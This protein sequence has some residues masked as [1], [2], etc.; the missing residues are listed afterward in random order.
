MATYG[1]YETVGRLYSIGARSVYS[2]REVEGSKETFVVKILSPDDVFGEDPQDAV[3]AFT[4]RAQIQQSL[5]QARA[6]AWAEVFEV[7]TRDGEVYY[8]SA[9]AASSAQ[10]LVAGKVRTEADDLYRVV[11]R[12]IQGLR[13]LRSTSQRAHGNLKPSN[14]LIDRT[15]DVASASVLLTDP[16][17]A[18][19]KNAA[20]AEHADVRDLGEIIHQLV[21]HIPFRAMGGYPIEDSP[22][23]AR[24]GRFAEQWRA[25]CNRML[26]P[27]AQPG[28][29]SVEAIAQEI[30]GLRP[31]GGKGGRTPLI[32]AGAA[33][34]L[35]LVAGAAYVALRPAPTPTGPAPVQFEPAEWARLCDA[36]LWAMALRDALRDDGI[37][38]RLRE[39]PHLA[40][41]L[42]PLAESEV[43]LDVRRI[44]G[45]RLAPASIRDDPP[46]SVRNPSSAVVIRDALDWVERAEAAVSPSQWPAART[47]A[48]AESRLRA[49]GWDRFADYPRALQGRLAQRDDAT[50]RSFMAAIQ[51]AARVAPQLDALLAAID[52]AQPG[53]EDQVPVQSRVVSRILNAENDDSIIEGVRPSHIATLIAYLSDPASNVR[54]T[55]VVAANPGGT[56]FDPSGTTGQATPVDPPPVIPDPPPV[57]DIGPDP[58]TGWD[59]AGTIESVRSRLAERWT[60]DLQGSHVRTAEQARADLDAVARLVAQVS[61][62][63]W[64]EPTRD[65]VRQQMDEA[66]TRADLVSRAVDDLR[67]DHE[68]RLAA[69]AQTAAEAQA[70]LAAYVADFRARTPAG[71]RSPALLE[72]WEQGRSALIAAHT[73]PARLSDLR[74]AAG[75]LERAVGIAESGIPLP[76]PF[77]AGPSGF[78]AAAIAERLAAMREAAI[79]RAWAAGVPDSFGDTFQRAVESERGTLAAEVT[80]IGAV[81]ADL[82][83]AEAG[84]NAV[85]GWNDSL[86]RAEPPR[87]L[88]VIRESWT[89][90]LSQRQW[91]AGVAG[92]VA[93]RLTDLGAAMDSVGAADPAT[94]PPYIRDEGSPFVAA[95][96]AW[97]RTRA[98]PGITLE[99][100]QAM[101]QRLRAGLGSIE[102]EARRTLLRSELEAGALARWTAAIESAATPQEYESRWAARNMVESGVDLTALSQRTQ[103]N[104]A[105]VFG[106]QR[107]LTLGPSD[108]EEEARSRLERII[109]TAEGSPQLWQS[110]PGVSAWIAQIRAE[111]S[112]GSGVDLAALERSGPGASGGWQFRA[113][114]PQAQRIAYSINAG[115]ESITLEFA[116]LDTADGVSQPVYVGT[117][118]VSVRMLG[119]AAN[120][121][122][123]WG[124]IASAWG[125]RLTNPS[126]SWD[127]PRVWSYNPAQP[128]RLGLNNRW[129]S[130]QG[131]GSFNIAR[132]FANAEEPRSLDMPVQHITAPAARAFAQAIGCRLPTS[133]EWLAARRRE[134]AQGWNLR[135]SGFA[136][137][138]DYA[139][140]RQARPPIW[141]FPDD[142][143]FIPDGRQVPIGRS[144][145]VAGGAVDDALYFRD[146]GVGA[147]NVFR[148]I[149]GNV[150]EFVDDSPPGFTGAEEARAYRVIGGSA[151]SPPEL[152]IDEPLPI[153]MDP[154]NN[155]MIPTSSFADVGF[156]LAFP[157]GPVGAGAPLAER[158]AE[159]AR[160]LALVPAR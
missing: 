48:D 112:R 73:D 12:I 20:A 91:L 60:S 133:Q 145:T 101:Q 151:L 62:L 116:R 118:E 59:I 85:G 25:L 27:A 110:D 140:Q 21:L 9:R 5:T 39:V 107:L 102:N 123:A 18:E 129:L 134:T 33:A 82:A 46:P 122:G 124:R 23:W 67:R 132:P 71:V 8:V 138:R 24:L 115:G 119:A 86:T 47:L 121:S 53:R 142:M 89:A 4:R 43:E 15:G 83:L 14:V 10:Q 103:F 1:N 19:Q 32:I 113:L 95:M 96:A 152:G 26:D 52:A 109:A 51:D 40:G 2:A 49:L 38:Q 146:V 131:S 57:V 114:D 36:S 81:L 97:R 160:G 98:V 16:S 22:G 154:G 105:L 157:A 150:A 159:V 137:Q 79:E 135:G 28:S 100:E 7:G 108:P 78:D 153:V 61:D 64:A 30:E 50:V 41:A 13:E 66:R 58:R 6:E 106:A 104:L 120:A 80:A 34:G 148:H 117:T 45:S 72:K 125:D 90:A 55:V 44:A 93:Q 155:W 35:L 92:P 127:G 156:R 31:A 74:T 143:V 54:A 63:E 87:T 75:Q 42:L 136:A 70:A 139:A 147:G 17:G 56:G 65:R 29:L 11:W 76:P 68:A 69:Q 99:I 158:A 37:A 111:L 126:D 141:P 94:L 77:E 130:V 3:A 128:N 144:A 149:V 88:A 84:L